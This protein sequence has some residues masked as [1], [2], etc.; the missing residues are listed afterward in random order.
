MAGQ[1]VLAAAVNSVNVDDVDRWVLG[2]LL[3]GFAGSDLPDWVRAALDAGLPG[4]AL[5]GHNVTDDESLP[6]LAAGQG[7]AIRSPYRRH[8]Q[9]CSPGF[10]CVWF[11]SAGGTR[12]PAPL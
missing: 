11:D 12:P 5:Y 10:Y 7:H 2:A 1:A 4:V 6:R 3:P 9:R 8:T